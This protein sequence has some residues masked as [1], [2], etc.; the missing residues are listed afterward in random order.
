MSSPMVMERVWTDKSIYNDA[1]KKYYEV[2]ISYIKLN[3]IFK[4]VQDSK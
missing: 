1:E 4:I 2:R 3:L